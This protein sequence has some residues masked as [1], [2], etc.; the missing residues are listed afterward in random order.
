MSAPAVGHVAAQPVR[1]DAP[2]AQL[3]RTRRALVGVT[4]VRGLLLGIAAGAGTWTLLRV[5]RVLWLRMGGSEWPASDGAAIGVAVILALVVL[6]VVLARILPRLTTARVA[7]WV[8]EQVPGLD[9]ALVTAADPRAG[10]AER[11]APRL[12]RVPWQELVRTASRRRLLGPA[13]AAIAALGVAFLLPAS[14]R[15]VHAARASDATTSPSIA[16]PTRPTSGPL[17]EIR[18][19][20]VP[21]AYS[22][23]PRQTLDDPTTVAA[24]V[25]STVS[26][27]GRAPDS[28][29]VRAAFGDR[30]LD[31]LRADAR[32]TTTLRMPAAAG[33]VRLSAPGGERLILLEP[34]PDSAPVVTLATSVVDTVLRE[35]S[36]IIALE[37]EARDD[38]GLA[39]S[40]WEWIVT[41][42]DGE[43]FQARTGTLGE[44]LHGG[45][46]AATLSARLDLTALAVK[47]GDVVH[48][49]ATATDRNDV[50]GPGVGAS[51][52]RTI[53]IA[54]PGEYDSL[55]FEGIAPPPTDS[56]L[57][58]QR[59]LLLRAERLVARMARI[60]RQELVDSSRSLAADQAT[61]R[62]RVGRLVYQKLGE[63]EDAEHAH[64]PGDGHDHGA[65]G[66][67][68]PD[69]I[70]ARADAAT[71]GGP[72]V[73]D[74]EGDETP[75]V[76][77]NRPLLEAYN[78]MWDAGRALEIADPRSAIPSMRRALEAIQR[79]R[80]AERYYLRGQPPRVVVD[81]AAAR[82][83]GKAEGRGSA[84]T[85]LDPA[86]PAARER[87]RRLDAAAVLARRDPGA[88]ADSL[89]VLRLEAAADP[90]LAATLDAAARQLREGAPADDE[91]ARARRLVLPG[92]LR[93]GA[94]D[95]WR[96]W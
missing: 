53:R 94:L 65:E 21:P 5:A 89:I 39:S 20:V 56:A 41:S 2:L 70:L 17:A 19:V 58:S 24:L 1:S 9:Y 75:V 54:R 37:A 50:T 90:E 73:L 4:V 44:A 18:A 28:G 6:A 34:R 23:L 72:V 92:G 52:T 78:H 27:S 51:E 71:G 76:A 60:E 22:G 83:T 69:D 40:R 80:E 8:E 85:P 74:F 95:A 48:V 11:L 82:L 3:E 93:R 66:R 47:A 61:L 7:L 96:G 88:A 77:I 16:Q 13:V 68:D 15:A 49:R 62:R 63:D 46:R 45:R 12:G 86:D 29:A 43:L 81:V 32:W 67:I 38:L 10:A 31:V 57:L 25:G 36:G 42:G 91:L 33:L 87:A 59:M 79:A 84:R 26:L 35:P 14:E 55:T 30:S 64:F